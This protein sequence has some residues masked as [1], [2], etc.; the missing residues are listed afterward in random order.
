MRA[1]V[2]AGG[3]AKRLWPLTLD[4][5]KPLLPL[6]NGYILDFVISGIMSVDDIS[7]IIISTNKR[8]ELNFIEWLK[9]RGHSNIIVVPEPSMREEEKLGPINAVWAIVKGQPDDYLIVAG[10]NLFSLDLKE[11]VSFYHKVKAPIIALFEI[12][13]RELAKQ[14]ACVEIDE[15]SCVINFEEK[16]R[17]PKSLLVSTGI[18]VLPW[19]SLSRIHEYLSKGNPPDPIGKFIEWLTRT[20][21]VYGFKFKGYWYDI[22][23]HESYRAAKEAFKDISFKDR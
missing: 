16:P 14:Y 20:E 7:E 1:I 23:S 15:N 12:N 21:A 2:L 10:D 5:P 22:G 17:E 6:G 19:R 3:Y 18:Y 9:E 8:F 13:D 4:R 11:M